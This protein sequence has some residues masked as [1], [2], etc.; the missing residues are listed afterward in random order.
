MGDKLITMDRQYREKH[1]PKGFFAAMAKE[2]RGSGVA[3]IICGAILA[4]IGGGILWIVISVAADGG[5]NI[6]EDM[7]EVIFFSI[8]GLIFLIPG[9]LIIWFGIK[10][11]RTNE[12]I[13]LQKSVEAS[14]Y[15]ESV[16]RDFANQAL[17]DGSLKMLLGAARTQGFLTRDYIFFDNLVYPCVI[18]IEDIAGAYLVQTSY[19][20]NVNNKRVRIYSKNIMVVSNHKTSIMSE[21]DEDTVRQLLDMLTD[22][23]PAIDTEGGRMLSENEYNEKEEMLKKQAQDG[24]G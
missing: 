14:G 12:D 13:W 4:F 10:R 18:K 3:L 19:T 20:T 2:G 23:N 21:A 1:Y 7:S 5:F 17:E 15:P 22:K 16:M 11:C 9:L 6:S 24:I 8:V